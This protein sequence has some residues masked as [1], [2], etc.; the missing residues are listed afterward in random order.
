MSYKELILPEFTELIDLPDAQR[1]RVMRI[2]SAPAEN[3]VEK[4]IFRLFAYAVANKASDL[5][6]TARDYGAGIEVLVNARLKGGLA[7][8][9]Y[10]GEHP[11]HFEE[12]LFNLSNIG[13]GTHGES[14]S[15]S[16]RMNFPV[17]WAAQY[18]L[19][20]EDENYLIDVRVQ[21][22]TT[23]DGYTTVCRIL[24]SQRA[25]KL[26]DLGLSMALYSEI[27]KVLKRPSGL[28]L[29]TGPTGSG[30]STLMNAMIHY[31]N[32]GTRSFV[33]IEDPKEYTIKGH[34]SISQIA[35]RGRLTFAE[36]LRSA[37]RLDPDV[38]MIGEIRDEETMEIALK[39]SQTG[40]IV[41]STVHA[42]DAVGAFTRCLDLCPDKSRD[43]TRIANCVKLV[44]AQRLLDTYEGVT[45]VR[46]LSLYEKEL[47]TSNGVLS[48]DHLLETTGI[49]HTGKIPVIEAIRMDYDIM[50][51]IC[52]PKVEPENIFRLA[53]KQLQY[54]SQMLSGFRHVEAGKC[55]LEQ[56]EKDLH[57]NP[58]AKSIPP[59]R[60]V[61]AKQYDVP[62]LTV[63]KAIDEVYALSQDNIHT[64]VDDVLHS[65]Q[66]MENAIDT[67]RVQ[68]A[69]LSAVA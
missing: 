54:E 7:T 28:I 33:T 3:V 16:F 8:W 15:S 57:S 4:D 47:L 11:K 69:A 17:D 41:I 56:C 68:N 23:A 34:T 37:M 49:E 13:S 24:D 51:E 50:R 42:D 38:I 66:V 30:K 46:A 1:K 5:H 61:L 36:G 6:F 48:K 2:S 55:R 31:L 60:T 10:K 53:A 19:E 12:K 26:E 43:A 59:L 62:Y 58:Y 14:I 20:S 52:A 29:V 18:G 9:R 35:V 25:P 21:Y 39:A 40:H 22:Q 63:A 45:E 27:T 67:E 65:Y 44:I 32:D 64:T